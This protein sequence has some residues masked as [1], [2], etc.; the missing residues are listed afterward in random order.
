VQICKFSPYGLRFI[1]RMEKQ[2]GGWKN[3]PNEDGVFLASSDN[4]LR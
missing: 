2:K 4:P 3:F 1:R